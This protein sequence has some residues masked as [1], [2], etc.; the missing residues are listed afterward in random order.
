MAT[1]TFLQAACTLAHYA[2]A[3]A[4][5]HEPDIALLCAFY[6]VHLAVLA[7]LLVAPRGVAMARACWWL[8]PLWQLACALVFYLSNINDMA[9]TDIP[10]GGHATSS[11]W[12]T[13]DTMGFLLFG[14]AMI[15]VWS[16]YSSYNDAGKCSDTRRRRHRPK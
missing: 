12:I 15:F 5:R 1:A 6:V 14:T 8:A 10:R 9:E 11:M 2:C 16:L 7:F 3:M 4:V 13:W